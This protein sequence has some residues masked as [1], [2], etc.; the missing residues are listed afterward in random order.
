METQL[1]R[2]ENQSDPTVL[3]IVLCFACT[4]GHLKGRKT[5]K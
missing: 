3:E 1:L 5:N 2:A 4:P